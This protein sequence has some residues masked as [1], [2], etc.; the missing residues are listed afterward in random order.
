[1][2][3]A[4]LQLNF[5]RAFKSLDLHDAAKDGLGDGDLLLAVDVE[6]VASEVLVLLELDLDDKITATAV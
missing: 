5:L 6:A 4:G 3:S 1:M 2:R